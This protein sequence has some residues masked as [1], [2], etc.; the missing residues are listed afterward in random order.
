MARGRPPSSTRLLRESLDTLRIAVSYIAQAQTG[1]AVEVHTFSVLLMQVFARHV[2]SLQSAA[3]LQ[4]LSRVSVQISGPVGTHGAP[5]AAPP[6][7]PPAAP[8]AVPPA[9]PPAAPPA[10]PPAIPPAV[11]PAVPPAAP[12]A[13]PPAA[14]PAAP[15]AVPAAA[16]P[17]VPPPAPPSGLDWRPHAIKSRTAQSRIEGEPYNGAAVCADMAGGMDLGGVGSRGKKPLDAVIN[18]VPF[19]DLMA[20]TIAFLLITAVWSQ[21]GAQPVSAPG[22]GG[23][24]DDEAPLTLLLTPH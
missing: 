11:P 1:G 18:L 6:A 24:K 16:P 5:P 9:A 8:P 4:S 19:I 23:G 17:A 12:P 3:P 7:V 14:P 10:V 22:K 13:V 21:A 20:V 2:V 15:P